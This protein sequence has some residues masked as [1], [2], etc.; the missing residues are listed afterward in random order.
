ML[1]IKSKVRVGSPGEEYQSTKLKHNNFPDEES[2]TVE[3]IVGQVEQVEADV[4]EESSSTFDSSQITYRD[5]NVQKVI[6]S[7]TNLPVLCIDDARRELRIFREE[8]HQVEKAGVLADSFAGWQDVAP[9]SITGAWDERKVIKVTDSSCNLLVLLNDTK[10]EPVV[11][12]ADKEPGLSPGRLGLQLGASRRHSACG[13]SVEDDAHLGDNHKVDVGLD[14]PVLVHDNIGNWSEENVSGIEDPSMSQLGS[15]L[16]SMTGQ[17]E[18]SFHVV[19][20]MARESGYPRSMVECLTED[21]HINQVNVGLD[22]PELVIDNVGNWPEEIMSMVEDPSMLLT[23]SGLVCMSALEEAY[24]P[25]GGVV[26]RVTG[27]SQKSGLWLTSPTRAWLEAVHQVVQDG[28]VGLSQ[29]VGHS[30]VPAVGDEQNVDSLAQHELHDPPGLGSGVGHTH[31]LEHRLGGQ[32]V[33]DVLEQVQGEM[34]SRVGVYTR[35]AEQNSIGSS[36]AQGIQD[37][38]HIRQHQP[39]HGEGQQHQGQ[40]SDVLDR[41]G[42]SLGDGWLRIRSQEGLGGPDQDGHHP[43][44]PQV[45]PSCY[46]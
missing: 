11:E 20:E 27:H 24:V 43:G 30:E 4:D 2:R 1:A 12:E 28:G 46:L 5:G 42:E 9:V 16:V 15:G 32:V 41:K 45:L 40:P 36:V 38:G 35:Q 29:G 39:G 8:R 25:V 19:G 6:N 14:L 31:R 3:E 34:S 22:L 37:R 7:S 21:R 10:D 26:S 13:A 33:N 18:A 23:H 17:E 44:Q